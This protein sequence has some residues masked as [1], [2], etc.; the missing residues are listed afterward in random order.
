MPLKSP[1]ID[2]LKNPTAIAALKEK[3]AEEVSNS[4]NEFLSTYEPLERP[5]LLKDTPTLTQFLAISFITLIS[6]IKECR[7]GFRIIKPDVFSKFRYLVL[8]FCKETGKR[9]VSLANLF[10]SI[11]ASLSPKNV[12]FV[13][14]QMFWFFFVSI[15]IR[16]PLMLYAESVALY[17]C[18]AL[19]YCPYA[20]TI[21]GIS[22]YYMPLIYNSLFEVVDMLKIL[23]LAPR[24]IIQEILLQEESLQ[25]ITLCGRKAVAWSDPVKTE[26]IKSTAKKL[27]VSEIEVSL[28]ACAMCISKYFAQTNETI[29]TVLPVTMRNIS[30][31]YLFATG[32]NIKPEDSVSGMICLNLPIV[33]PH[34][35]ATQL[36]NFKVLQQKFR[37]SIEKQGLSHLLTLLQTRFGILTKFL[38]A[39]CL[40]IYLKY[41][42]RKYAVTFMEVSNRYPNVNQRTLWG[43]EVVSAIYWRPPQANTSKKSL[44]NFVYFGATLWQILEMGKISLSGIF[45]N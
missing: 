11:L 4:W 28:S 10:W 7:R 16:L 18:V 43:Q 13:S 24:T 1:I 15:P 3:V 5:E 23:F 17:S 29:P 6:I 20:H 35:D 39:T 27:G 8:T 12:L 26:L 2:V 32:P 22:Y 42:S 38:P 41:L 36:D 21:V 44:N 9:H 19:K 40:S 33:D 45:P 31:Q 30:S 14:F 25:T 37:T 34:S